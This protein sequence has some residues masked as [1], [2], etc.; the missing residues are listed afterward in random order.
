MEKNRRDDFNAFISLEKQMKK[1]A[2]YARDANKVH[3]SNKNYGINFF[4]CA[5][6]I[7]KSMWL[8]WIRNYHGE[9][10]QQQK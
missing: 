5:P 7:K 3:K 10:L 6:R 1:G 9:L 2:K 8:N 4:D